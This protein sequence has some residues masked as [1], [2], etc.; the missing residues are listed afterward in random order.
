MEKVDAV[1]HNE[2]ELLSLSVVKKHVRLEEEYTD[3]DELI[4]VYMASAISIAENYIERK[5]NKGQAVFP[6][7]K[8]GL[9]GFERMSVNDVVSKVEVV[10][11]EGDANV[12]E[13]ASY[14]QTKFRGE[15]YDLKLDNVILGPGES[16]TVT[17]DYGFGSGN[18]PGDIKS[19]LLLLV[20]DL[21]EKREDRNVG[22][23]SVVKNLLRPYRKWQ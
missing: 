12:I 13:T 17:V 21:F 15:Y 5:L 20:G 4:L 8:G 7:L 11:L 23:N 18:L 3:E 22:D 16:F 10:K 19:A 6:D 1:V 2:V 9:I 14:S